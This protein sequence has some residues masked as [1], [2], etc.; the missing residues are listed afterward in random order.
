MLQQLRDQTQ[1]TGFKVLVIAIIAVLVFFGFG[2]TNV[3]SVGDPEVAEVGTLRSQ[4][5]SSVLRL[6]ASVVVSLGRWGPTSIR[7]ILIGCSCSS[8]HCRS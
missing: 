4:K 2:A 3:F 5:I 6:S 1:S 8:M 7:M